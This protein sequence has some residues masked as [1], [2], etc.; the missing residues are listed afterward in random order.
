MELTFIEEAGVNRPF[1]IAARAPSPP[2][3]TLAAVL[4]TVWVYS[5]G[6][7]GLLPQ[8]GE[9]EGGQE[10]EESAGWEK[11]PGGLVSVFYLSDRA[12]VP[13][14]DFAAAA[15]AMAEFHLEVARLRDVDGPLERVL[16]GWLAGRP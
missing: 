8:L 11:V 10:W 2:A 4:S 12:L 1:Q 15:R 9:A 16:R 7:E 14:R 3:A 5:D 13:E 6:P